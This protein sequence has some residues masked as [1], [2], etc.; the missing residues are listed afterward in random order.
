MND[1]QSTFLISFASFSSTSCC[2]SSG[3]T[4][5]IVSFQLEASR[6]SCCVHSRTRKLA[7]LV[8]PAFCHAIFHHA[9]ITCCNVSRAGY[10]AQLYSQTFT[11][12]DRDCHWLILGHVALTKIKCIPIVI[13][14]AMQP[15]RDT[16]QHVI[17]AWWKVARQEAGKTNTVSF[18][19]RE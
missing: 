9:L 17:K 2:F 16:L 6:L 5:K 15:A 12:L 1:L 11:Q 19:F 7:V 3:I 18:L 13:H 14:E 10:I 4:L 8:F